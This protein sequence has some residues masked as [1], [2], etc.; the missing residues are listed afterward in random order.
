MKETPVIV[1]GLFGLMLKGYPC[2]KCGN[3]ILTLNKPDYWIAKSC[4]TANCHQCGWQKDVK[5]TPKP[6]KVPETKVGCLTCGS[7][8]E[9]NPA[10]WEI[11][12]I[13]KFTT[14]CDKHM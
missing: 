5:T 6:I 13:L 14:I 1:N 3:K 8:P 4:L 12:K 9:S 11:A 2:P 7:T 10:D